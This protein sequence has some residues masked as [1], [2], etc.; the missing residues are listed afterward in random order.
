MAL[1]GEGMREGLSCILS[2][3]L[4][5]PKFSSQTRTSWSPPRFARPIEGIVAERLEQ[6][7]EEHPA[8]AKKI[9]AKVVEAAAA[10]EAAARR[11]T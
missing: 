11:A 2:V 8:D 10:R 3:K 9:V 7:F 4:P 1:A 5:D 6:W